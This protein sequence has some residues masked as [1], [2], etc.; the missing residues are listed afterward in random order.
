MATTDNQNEVFDV[1]DD[2]DRVIGQATRGELH[3]NTDLTHRSVAVLV[4]RAKELFLQKR[5]ATKDK[6]PK[7]WTC[8]VT[9]HVDSGETYEEAASRELFEEVGIPASTPM[10]QITEEVFKYP[11]ETERMRFFRC[12]S[13]HPIT[14][15]PTEISEGKFF[16]L[17]EDF[18]ERI[19]P[20]LTITPPLQFILDT[21]R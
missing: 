1:V 6:Y 18:F 9:G 7:Y 2:H 11:Y 20:T 10:T 5:S 21:L 4:F 8:S 14:L 12:E 13:A 16:E 15:H 3:K 19:L 17:N